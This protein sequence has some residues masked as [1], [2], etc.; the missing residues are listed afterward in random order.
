METTAIQRQYDEVIA[1][2]YDRDAQRVTQDSL[3]KAVAQLCRQD[4]FTAAEEPLR[5]L[6]LG[7]GTGLFYERLTARSAREVKAFG[8]DLSEKMVEIAREKLPGLVAAVDDAANFDAH[9]AGESFDLI[10]THF[11]TGFVPMETLAPKIMARLR[12]GGWWSFVGGTREGFPQLQQRANSRLIQWLFG[13]RQVDVGAMVHNPADEAE[14]TDNLQRHGFSVLDSETFQPALK[15]ANYND[16]MAFAYYG[17]W[18]TPFIEKLK[19]HEAGAITRTLL[20][21]FV[22]P[23]H[24]QHSIAIVLGQ[25][26][27][28]T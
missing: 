10:C 6:D 22:F 18:L 20:N 24:D 3:D 8:V 4:E 1:S 25:K 26:P 12:P 9:F 13:G 23:V 7:M 15:F 28:H 5:V 11:L 19:L 21:R 14:V 27:H 17:G 2:H 16:F